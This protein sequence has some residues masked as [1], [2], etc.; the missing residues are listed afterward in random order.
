MSCSPSSDL[1]AASGFAS[2]AFP[3]SAFTILDIIKEKSLLCTRFWS[4]VLYVITKGEA[5]P[6]ETSSP[7][8]V[9]LKKF[10]TRNRIAKAFI[11]SARINVVLD[12]KKNETCWLCVLAYDTEWWL[13]KTVAQ[14]IIAHQDSPPLYTI[15]RK[16]C[17]MKDGGGSPVYRY[18]FWNGFKE[19]TKEP[20]KTLEVVDVY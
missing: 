10:K 3:S 6:D 15:R 4:S 12:T 19:P 20:V 17:M 14:T 8:K 18:V 7:A 5:K 9:L 16:S 11:E 2:S 13:S 1:S